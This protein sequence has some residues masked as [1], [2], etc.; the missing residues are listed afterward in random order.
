METGEKPPY[1]RACLIE[2]GNTLRRR[3]GPGALAVATLSRL[4]EIRASPSSSLPSCSTIS[5]AIVCESPRK[6]PEWMI[7]RGCVAIDSIRHPAEVEALRKGPCPFLLLHVTAP[8]KLRY[9]WLLS[10]N[11]AGDVKTEEEF[12]AAEELELR[13]PDKDGQQ[14][15]DVFAEA[16]LQ[17]ENTA[18]SREAF[19]EYLDVFF[20]SAVQSRVQ[21]QPDPCS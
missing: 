11:R 19:F 13:H 21:Q 5:D 20:R 4:D 1:T 17:L 9:A 18:A 10:R 8:A 15:L 7:G 14:L 3:D 6:L 12:V 2:A 16:D